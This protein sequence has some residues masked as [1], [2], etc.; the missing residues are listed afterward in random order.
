MANPSVRVQPGDVIT[1]DLVNDLLSRVEV[2]ESQ[3]SNIGL[4]LGAL[5]ADTH[6]LVALGTG[7]ESGG[8][9]WLDGDPLLTV[10]T[11][12]G[13]HLVILD[14]T[15]RLKFKKIYDVFTPG[16]GTSAA[17]DEMA[18][19]LRT[20]TSQYDI[21]AAV[22][23]ESYV[24]LSP[25][26]RAA[27]A[28]VG[29]ASL[30]QPGRERDNAAFIGVVPAN[31]AD[32]A[33]FD[34]LTSVIPADMPGTGAAQAAGL[35]FAW[36]IYSV[37]MR[38]FVAGGTSGSP[39]VLPAHSPKE[40][41]KEAAKDTKDGKDAKDAVKEGKEAAKDNKDNKDTKDASKEGKEVTKDTKDH[42]DTKLTKEFEKVTK[43]TDKGTTK[44][45]VREDKG[46]DG[47][48][49]KVRDDVGLIPF[50][51]MAVRNGVA[52]APPTVRAFIR[53]EERP[54]LGGRALDQ[55]GGPGQ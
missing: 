26:A 35:A 34:Y 9:I 4:R 22:T 41:E 24:G 39:V 53:P 1:S 6:T 32:Q 2:L 8:G 18:A 44:E 27:L 21:V 13:I 43:E 31:N 51:G 7:F 15:L 52:D 3:T 17:A 37:P 20:Q 10:Q 12:R 55:P 14:A 54:E 38:R 5:A 48:R 29:A 11:Q 28:S 23:H 36:G 46:K 40:K 45:F 19:V 50:G 25:A 49:D 16:G 42:R 30:A 47:V 33:S